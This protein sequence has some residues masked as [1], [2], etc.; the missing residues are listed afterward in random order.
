ML[1]LGTILPV[2]QF[3][4]PFLLMIFCY[5]MIL[6]K[7]SHDML[8]REHAGKILQAQAAARKRRCMIIL[9]LMVIAFV[10]SWVPLTLINIFRDYGLL[11]VWFEDQ[12][13]FYT[14]IAHTLAMTS[15]IWN[16]VSKKNRF[17]KTGF[18]MRANRFLKL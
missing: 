1:F 2:I 12:L 9:V 17:L 18:L 13:F 15:L 16:P 10:C 7:V 4:L 8:I 14:L 6:I 3:L 5:T 11:A